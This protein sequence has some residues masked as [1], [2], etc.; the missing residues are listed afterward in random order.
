MTTVNLTSTYEVWTFGCC[1]FTFAV[2]RAFATQR[3]N[4]HKD[5]HCPN[6]GCVRCFQGETEAQRLKRQR[7]QAR[8]RASAMQ[9]QRDQSREQ[10]AHANRSRASLKG[11]LKRTKNRVKNG[12]CPCCNR[13][14]KNLHRHMQS[15]HPGYGEGE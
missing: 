8:D 1:G 14:F 12:V 6:C 9:R 4:D 13:H 11:H 2:P 10:L 5:I 15:Q 7:D 3:R